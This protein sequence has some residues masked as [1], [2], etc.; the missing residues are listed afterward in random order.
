MR[1]YKQK[2]RARRIS[3]MHA[4]HGNAY[5]RVKKQNLQRKQ[6][7]F[8]AHLPGALISLPQNSTVQEDCGVHLSSLT[9]YK[10]ILL[11]HARTAYRM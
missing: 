3:R 1:Q 9:P 11:L 2:K 6:Q 10:Y 5:I 7:T 4:T 8:H